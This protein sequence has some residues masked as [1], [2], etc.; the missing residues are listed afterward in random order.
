M[1]IKLIQFTGVEKVAY[2]GGNALARF[3]RQHWRDKRSLI[4]E[5][6]PR[7]LLF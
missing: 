3:H 7:I 2:Y 6:P 1:I 5:T 4:Q